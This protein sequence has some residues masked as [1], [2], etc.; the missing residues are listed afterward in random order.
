MSGLLAIT[1]HA[2]KRYQERITVGCPTESARKA[3]ERIVGRGIKIGEKND[4][5]YFYKG[6]AVAVLSGHTVLTVYR[7]T[8][9]YIQ[10][11][12]CDTYRAIRAQKKS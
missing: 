3:L 5:Q 11:M 9:P 2:V 7:P 4:A 8:E 10:A 1:E 6:A 12:I